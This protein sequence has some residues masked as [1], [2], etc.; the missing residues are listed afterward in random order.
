MMFGTRASAAKSMP[1]AS[2]SRIASWF[3]TR[4]RPFSIVTG[5]AERAERAHEAVLPHDRPVASAR[6][7]R[8]PCSRCAR[9]GRRARR[10]SSC[11]STSARPT[12]SG[13]REPPAPR[14]P[15]RRAARPP[16]RRPPRAPRPRPERPDVPS[17]AS[18]PSPLLGSPFV[19]RRRAAGYQHPSV[20]GVRAVH[21]RT[22]LAT[23][24]AARRVHVARPSP[25]GSPCAA[26]TILASAALLLA[27]ATSPVTA[28]A[29]PR[30]AVRYLA[31]AKLFVL[32]TEPHVLRP[33][34]ERAERG[35]ARLLGRAPSSATP[36]SARAH[37]RG[38][39]LRVGRGPLR[40]RVPRL[41][42]PA[43]RRAVPQ[44]ELR[45]RRPR[46]RPQ[47]RVA[48]D[49]GRRARPAPE[50]RR[51][52]PRRR[53]RL[54]RLP[55]PRHPR[56]ARDDP[57]RTPGPVVVESAASG[58]FHCR[59]ACRTTELPPDPSGR[60]VGG[61]DAGR[62][63]PI[64]PGQEGAREPAR[65]HQPPGEP[66]VRHRRAAAPTRS[67]DGLVRRARLER[68]L[69]AHR[70]AHPGPPRARRRR[71]QRLRLRLPPGARRIARDAALLRRLHRRTASARRSRLLHRSRSRRSCPTRRASASRSS[72]TP[73]RRPSS[74]STSRARRSW[75][76]KAA[77]LG[78]E[79]LRDRRRLVRRARPRPR[80]P[81]RLGPSTRR[82]SRT[83]SSP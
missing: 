72:T 22:N 73:G 25:G 39:R 27:A 40:D 9:R 29:A 51:P 79:L 37:A 52:R 48:R 36:T 20:A 53:P 4:F 45:G 69:E 68:Q 64:Q 32:E 50:G 44:G 31:D 47:V 81:R 80:G 7:G 59:S 78:V 77:A 42:R 2:A 41:G 62:R 1:F 6:A 3:S 13:A 67:A 30:A 76:S 66:L 57:N 56:E 55:A 74:T 63:E 60:P 10:A 49:P 61:R 82:S 12:A 54:P 18:L 33:R 19:V 8:C 26:R 58:V 14:P 23:M 5:P 15:P 43:L 75:R 17:R 35:A 24:R 16:G 28:A 46:P 11:R 65:H 21:S 70:R 83:G 34:R 71:F 38:L